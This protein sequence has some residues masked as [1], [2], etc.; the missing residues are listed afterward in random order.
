[1]P[2]LAHDITGLQTRVALPNPL[3]G[4]FKPV[5]QPQY[6]TA[7]GLLRY[8]ANNSEVELKGEGATRS[9][10]GSIV[11]TIKGWFRGG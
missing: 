6:A 3:P 7:V 11:S 9:S 10:F 1:M 2:E 8:A 4:N 5:R